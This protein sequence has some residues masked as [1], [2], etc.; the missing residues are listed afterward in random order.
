MNPT[1]Q[2]QSQTVD[3]QGSLATGEKEA[4]VEVVPADA[5]VFAAPQRERNFIARPGFSNL[6]DT[7][8]NGSHY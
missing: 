2:K 4:T 7:E 6:K 1:N 3:T 8:S 5:N